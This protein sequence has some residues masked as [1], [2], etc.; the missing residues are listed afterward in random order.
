MPERNYVLPCREEE[1]LQ[2][3]LYREGIPCQIFCDYG[4]ARENVRRWNKALE[5]KESLL[6][7]VPK[8]L[9]VDFPQKI[10]EALVLIRDLDSQ[11]PALKVVY[12]RFR[13]AQMGIPI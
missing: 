9:W 1:I 12:A 10:R 4:M 6:V 3:S 5:K 13:M 7:A 2:D 11:Y 8:G